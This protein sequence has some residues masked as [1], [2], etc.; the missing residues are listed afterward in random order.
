MRMSLWLLLRTHLQGPHHSCGDSSAWAF[1]DDAGGREEGSREGQWSKALYIIHVLCNTYV[2]VCVYI[3]HIILSPREWRETRDTVAHTAFLSRAG[4]DAFMRWTM[5]QAVSNVMSQGLASKYW[6]LIYPRV[7]WG[8]ETLASV[9]FIA[10]LMRNLLIVLSKWFKAKREEIDFP[11]FM[12]FYHCLP[13]P[14]VSQGGSRTWG[15][16]HRW[17]GIAPVSL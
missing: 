8:W 16:R 4:A 17:A 9:C 3:Y 15:H 1:T 11:S 10:L 7:C 5:L 6:N 13:L 14:S 2:C 12:T